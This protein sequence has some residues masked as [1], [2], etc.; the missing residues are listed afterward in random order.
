M[1]NCKAPQSNS[2][3]PST[4]GCN[5]YATGVCVVYIA[6]VLFNDIILIGF[7]F[8]YSGKPGSDKSLRTVSAMDLTDLGQELARVVVG[9]FIVHPIC[10]V[11]NYRDGMPE[12]AESV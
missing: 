4:G 2:S 3:I 6:Q 10:I 1:F 11:G 12:P 7:T 5:Y 9:L 8:L